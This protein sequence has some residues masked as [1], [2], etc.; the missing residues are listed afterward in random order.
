M[1]GLRSAII[2]GEFGPGHRLIET[3][4]AERFGATRASI[5][6]ALIESAN[7]GLIERIRHKGAR[8]RSVSLEEALEITEVRMVLEGLCAYKA[9]ERITSSQCE[10]LE[11]IGRRMS[12]AVSGGDL[13]G[14]SDFNRQLHARM[15]EIAGHGVASAL[16]QR[17]RGQSGVTHQFRL[18]LRPGR[19]SISLKEHLR[20]VDAVVA[21]DPAAAEAAMR[22]HLASVTATLRAVGDESLPVVGDL[23]GRSNSR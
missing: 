2:R 10:E 8:V 14:Y 13:L 4:L 11:E 18:A 23:G 16:I 17:L 12:S 1:A 7:E 15:H 6:L 20:I 22:S 19:P 21:R 3:E 9:A 5:R